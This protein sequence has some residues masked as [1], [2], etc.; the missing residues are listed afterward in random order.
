MTRVVLVLT[1]AP[2]G[3]VAERLATVLVSERLAACVNVSAAMTSVYRWQ[4]SIE[5]EAESQLV[6]KT[7][8][9]RVTALQHRIKELHSYELP[10]FLVLAAID[11]SVA[12]R[13]WVIA[14][15]RPPERPRP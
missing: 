11:V 13:V 12:Y 10:E 3:D 2:A 6:I 15:T 5:H 14:A 1:T 9:D 7:A 4:G 8:D